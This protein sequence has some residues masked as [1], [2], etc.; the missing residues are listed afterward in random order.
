MIYR[1]TGMQDDSNLRWPPQIKKTCLPKEN[2]F[3]Q[4]QDNPPKVEHM[5]RKNIVLLILY[6]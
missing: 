1:I 5:L 3:M 2:V 6:T 4:I